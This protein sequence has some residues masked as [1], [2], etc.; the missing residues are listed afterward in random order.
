MTSG[1]K[2]IREL[3]NIFGISLKKKPIVL[4]LGKIPEEIKRK[5]GH[6]FLVIR[7]TIIKQI[8]R[9][10]LKYDNLNSKWKQ[11]AN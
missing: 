1:K 8:T 5:D 9:N 2:C 11:V 4:L 6:L 7:I 10:W 3:S